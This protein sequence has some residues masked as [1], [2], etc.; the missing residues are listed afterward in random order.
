[1]WFVTPFYDQ[2]QLRIT[3]EDIRR[4]IGEFSEELEFQPAKL[5]ARLAQAFS[6]TES[7]IDL[8]EDEIEVIPDIMPADHPEDYQ[9]TDGYGYMSLEL[10]DEI[11]RSVNTNVSRP[12]AAAYQV[13]D[14]SRV[15][16]F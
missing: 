12:A 4:G 7:S 13:G 5:G 9:F 8:K 15:F 2:N 10:A 1:V 16:L 11:W 14:T 6:T 3:A